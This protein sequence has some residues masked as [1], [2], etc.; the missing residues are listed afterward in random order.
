[1]NCFVKSHLNN[2]TEKEAS[3]LYGATNCSDND[4]S[5]SQIA[6]NSIEYRQLPREFDKNFLSLSNT[7]AAGDNS[8]FFRLN[9]SEL[10]TQS[11]LDSAAADVSHQDN[12]ECVNEQER[13][14]ADRLQRESDICNLS[15]YRA[16]GNI[17]PTD[18]DVNDTGHCASRSCTASKQDIIDTDTDSSRSLLS[19]D[20]KRDVIVDD[21]WNEVLCSH[22]Q[23]PCYQASV[24][25]SAGHITFGRKLWSSPLLQETSN[26]TES[27]QKAS[28]FRTV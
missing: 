22:D 14:C 10:L 8:S 11:G 21:N 23:I 13:C 2:N 24:S 17:S 3:S 19:N 7:S 26:I 12:T 18:Q 20:C 6:S 25:V 9:H 1:M 5:P 28:A 27:L 16:I 4:M 15:E